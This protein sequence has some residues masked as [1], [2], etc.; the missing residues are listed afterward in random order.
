MHELGCRVMNARVKE[1]LKQ[2]RNIQPFNWIATG[3]IHFLFRA[4]GRKSKLVMKHLHRVGMVRAKLP[5]G[6]I[7]R[8]WSRADDWISTQ[9]FWKGWNAYETETL[10][11]FFKLASKSQTIL[12]IGAHVGLFSLVAGHANPEARIFA[13]EPVGESYERL[14][15]NVELNR[16]SNIR[17]VNS[18]VSDR[19]GAGEVF[20]QP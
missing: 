4:T 7:L 15:R 14:Q 19:D 5:N 9:I 11:L 18:A 12:D 6:H 10:E 13:F 2:L 1:R 8:L 17:C 20:H 3:F 16:L